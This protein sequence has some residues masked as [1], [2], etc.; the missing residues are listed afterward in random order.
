MR[1]EP[2]RSHLLVMTL[3]GL[4][5]TSFKRMQAIPD[6]FDRLIKRDVGCR[7]HLG[8]LVIVKFDHRLG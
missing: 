8:D 6:I 1:A 3:G 4:P 5:V 7:E 2:A